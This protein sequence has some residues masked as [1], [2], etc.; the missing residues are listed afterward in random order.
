MVH[1]SIYLV[2]ICACGLFGFSSKVEDDVLDLEVLKPIFT[3]HRYRLRKLRLMR[4]STFI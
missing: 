4:E 3:L 1:F 2:F